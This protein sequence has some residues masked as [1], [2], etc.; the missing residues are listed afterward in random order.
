LYRI[1]LDEETEA[2]QIEALPYEALA[3]LAELLDVLSLAPWNGDPLNDAN[4]DAPLRSWAFGRAGLL[5][6]LILEDQQ[7]VDLIRVVWVG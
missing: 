2:A 7:R 1:V 3:R 5:T 4:P 6:F